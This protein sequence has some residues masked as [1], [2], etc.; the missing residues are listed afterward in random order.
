MSKTLFPLRALIIMILAF[1]LWT[2]AAPYPVHAA[3]ITVT[4]EVD[5]DGG[6]ADCSLREAITAANSNAAYGGC[7]AGTAGLDTIAFSGVTGTINLGSALPNLAES[8][9]INGPGA[10]DLTIDGQ[11][12][13]FDGFSIIIPAG[14]NLAA[15]TLSGLTL[16]NFRHA[17][18]GASVGLEISLSD[19]SITSSG[20]GGGSVNNHGAIYVTSA[21][22]TLDRVTLSNN[23]GYRGGALSYQPTANGHTLTI[24]DS[25]FTNNAANAGSGGAIFL[26]PTGGGTTSHTITRSTLAGNTGAT[27]GAILV[28]VNG[29]TSTINIS[30]TTFSGNSATTGT[31]A[32]AA[33]FTASTAAAIVGNSQAT[34]TYSTFSGHNND[35]NASTTGVLHVS[36]ADSSSSSLSVTRTLIANNPASAGGAFRECTAGGGTTFGGSNNLTNDTFCAGRT[37]APTNVNSTLADNGGHTDTHALL[38]GSNAIDA[39]VVSATCVPGTTA[40]QRT[41]ARANGLNAGDSACDIG[42][43]EYS[44]TLTVLAIALAQWGTAATAATPLLWLGLALILLTLTLLATRLKWNRGS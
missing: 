41:A 16:T 38:A 14:G 8:I 17:L 22:L 36:R 21:D 30:H 43:Y 11:T 28:W 9:Q 7:A 5:E 33:Y 20:Q 42:A 2:T 37:A 12:D 13:S 44:S 40:D 25:T 3:T 10:A 39:L 1:A 26:Y 4:T 32:D 34:I 19:M 24:T 35:T 18:Y 29:A 23:T 31:G 6:G 27:A 15:V